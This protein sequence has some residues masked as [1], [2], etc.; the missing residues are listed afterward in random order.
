[1]TERY[2]VGTRRSPLARA[3]TEQVLARLTARVPECRFEPAPIDTGGDRERSIG[4]SPDF[5]DEIDRAL[6]GGE[7]DLA[8]H[9]AKDLPAELDRRF[10]LS[11]CLRR[12]DPRDG[13]LLAY[14]GPGQ[15]GDALPRGARVG[16]SS[17]R[18]RAQLLRWRP[19]LDVVEIRGN[20]GTRIDRLRSGRLDAIVLAVAG[21][22]RLGRADEIDTILPP[23]RFLPAPAQ[24]AL[25]VVTRRDDVALGALVRQIDHSATR[26]CVIAERSFAAALG[27]DCR[28]PLGA[29][30]TSDRD[31]ISLTG[32]VLTPDG[33]KSLRL[34][35][36]G[37]A[38]RARDL[39]IRLGT[40]ARDRG[41]LDLVA[42][43]RR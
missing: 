37:R 29:L 4:S 5:T 9:S 25:A 28:L 40:H 38:S 27:S 13:L 10:E 20:V 16:S 14:R 8:V 24:G 23:A 12:A 30:A 26:A 35:R 22:L 7:I 31:H 21:L 19:D 3:Q 32:E 33:R 39:G 42:P 36:E 17:P 43:V 34:R 2:R 15:G 11:A 41:A 6:L 1:V 18:R